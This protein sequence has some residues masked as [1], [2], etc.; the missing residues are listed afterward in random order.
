MRTLY[1]NYYMSI[2]TKKGDDGTT[3]IFGGKRFLKSDSLIEGYG[4]VDEV[5]SFI[6]L[7]YESVDTEDKRVL[8]ASQ[9][10]LY[11]IMADLSGAKLPPGKLDLEIETIEK[12]IVSTEKKLPKLTKFIIPQ[13]SEAAARLH[14]ARAVCRSA[15]RAIVRHFTNKDEI[16]N[17][18]QIIIY[19]NRLSDLLFLLA[20]K[21]TL[22]LELK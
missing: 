20:R 4:M 13:G 2:T 7:A 9:Q 10:S 1:N 18:A 5:T 22:D 8:T 21:Y 15:E 14:V 17:N 19:L 16:D 3:A 12:L 6:G 11:S